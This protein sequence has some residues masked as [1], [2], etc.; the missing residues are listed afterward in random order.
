M[1][2][3]EERIIINTI[4]FLVGYILTIILLWPF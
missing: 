4:A 2:T 1:R 3:K